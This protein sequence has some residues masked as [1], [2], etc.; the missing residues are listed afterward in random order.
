MW[1]IK[2][3]TNGAIQWNKVYG[4]TGVDST[5]ALIETKDGGFA[6]AGV[7][8]SYGAGG[9]DMW[10][11]KMRSPS[12]LEAL[13]APLLNFNLIGFIFFFI[14]LFLLIITI[15]KQKRG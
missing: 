15:K 2:T 1:L 7:T 6:L 4:G 9:P 5:S 11:I 12:P 8:A 13:L 14:T 3:D 10:L